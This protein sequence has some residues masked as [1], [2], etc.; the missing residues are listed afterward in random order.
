MVRYD[1]RATWISSTSEPTKRVSPGTWDIT[2]RRCA[3]L[4][5]SGLADFFGAQLARV[6]RALIPSCK[7]TCT[8]LSG[9]ENLLKGRRLHWLLAWV[10]QHGTGPAPSA[11][12]AV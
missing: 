12:Q 10:D 1:S 2:L 6:S 11:N 9:F 4:K 3:V 7:R 5:E 8:G